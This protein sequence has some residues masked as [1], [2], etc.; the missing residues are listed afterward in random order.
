MNKLKKKK[1]VFDST[2]RGGAAGK[3][4]RRNRL[5]TEQGA[6]HRAGSQDPEQG[7]DLSPNQESGLFFLR[8]YLFIHEKQRERG[9]DTGRGKKQA[10]CREPNVG[11]VGLHP[12]SPGSGP[13][14]KEVLNH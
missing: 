11:H 9:R 7:H 3:E 10:P 1:V 6:Q 2:G 5:R 14:L 4:R 8:F 13:G 12:G